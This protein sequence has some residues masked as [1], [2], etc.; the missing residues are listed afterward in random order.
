MAPYIAAHRGSTVVMHIPGEC[1]ES[2]LFQSLADDIVLL[3]TLGLK[4][5]LVVGCR[6]QVERRLY[7]ANADAGFNEYGEVGHRITDEFVLQQVVESW[8]WC[9]VQ[10]QSHIG[11]GLTT[12]E[13]VRSCCRHWHRHRF[14]QHRNCLASAPVLAPSMPR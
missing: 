5:V 2:D 12:G 8:G 13:E 9:R 7:A 1:L 4:L 3:H 11:R 14:H 6:P 10:L